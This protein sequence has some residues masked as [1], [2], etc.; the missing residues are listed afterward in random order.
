MAKLKECHLMVA[1]ELVKTSSCRAVAKTLGVDESSLRERLRRK[2]T[3]SV[4][5]RSL[6][7]ESCAPHEEVVAAWLHQ[8]E[9]RQKEKQRPSPVRELYEELVSERGYA[10]TYNS[11]VRYVNRRREKPAFQPCRRVETKPGAQAQVD[12]VKRPV[13]IDELKGSVIVSSFIMTLS[14]SRMW[15]A[16]WSLK[17]NQLSWLEC[18]NEAFR[19]LGGVP[20]SVRIDNL[21]TGVARGSGPWAVLNEAYEDYARQL[22]FSVDP[23][24]C[25]KPREKGK[26]ERR[27]KDVKRL[28]VTDSDRFLNLAELQ[29]VTRERIVFRSSR[30]KCPVTGQSVRETWGLEKS[31]LKSLPASLP[32]PFDVQVSRIAGRDCL[33]S[34]EGRQYS[35]PF[36]FSGQ[37]VQVRGCAQTV[38]I[39]AGG[40]KIA[41]FP[42]GT[43][44]RL[45]V[46]Q[47]HYEGEGTPRVLVPVPLG[48]KGREIA[49][50]R[51]WELPCAPARSIDRYEE[52]LRR[53]P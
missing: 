30:L 35:V 40:K 13:Y 24:R 25:R 48:H 42:R 15:A 44:C 38:E 8:Q 16:V 6:Q 45:L 34:F 18:H 27:A 22:G 10:G 1:E 29:S 33:V 4:D 28:Q 39:F 37:P 36:R 46:D 12:W 31:F 5:G 26:V 53:L 23:C 7:P 52:L 41:S 21:K 50:R 9:E 43:D 11:V 47:E 32:E 14:F 3:G 20:E 17:E 51:S 19:A 2:R 49:L